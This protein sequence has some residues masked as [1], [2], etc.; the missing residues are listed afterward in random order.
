MG[1]DV[2]MYLSPSY[3]VCVSKHLRRGAVN[4]TLLSLSLS[5][6]PHAERKAPCASRYE[7]LG[8]LLYLASINQ[9]FFI[10]TLNSLSLIY[11][12]LNMVAE[13]GW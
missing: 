8:L 11:P 7:A 13:R 2:N 9:S 6:L 12:H 4:D 1:L 5:L 10:I 3:S